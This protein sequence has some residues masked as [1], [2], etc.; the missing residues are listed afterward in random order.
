MKI[1]DAPVTLLDEIAEM[2]VR[3]FAVP[4][5][6][7][8]FA[9][10]F[11]SESI[12]VLAAMEG[13]I[14]LGYACLM[15]IAPEGELMNIAVDGTYRNRGIGTALMEAVLERA[16]GLGAESV[17]LEVRDSNASARHLYEK[18]GFEAVGRRKKYYRNP[19]E[20]AVV[21]RLTLA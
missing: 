2:E 13:D 1:I 4:W 7:Q 21:M 11:A 18:H 3:A 9:A 17:Y 16:A 12:T 14:L 10:A 5:S 19:V 15:V 20:D 6:K 8:V